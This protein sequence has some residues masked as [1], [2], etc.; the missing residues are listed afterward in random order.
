MKIFKRPNNDTYKAIEPFDEVDVE[1]TSEE[2]AEIIAD[3]IAK[4]VPPPPSIVSMRQARLALLH[5]GK[6]QAVNNAIAAMQG[7]QGE[8]AR[9]EWDYSN[10]VRR[11]QTLT[12]ALAQAIGMTDAEMDALFVEAAK[13]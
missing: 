4:N 10:E 2:L 7:P 9:I 5:A 13:L 1:I 12:I 3:R 11:T 8:A 6:L